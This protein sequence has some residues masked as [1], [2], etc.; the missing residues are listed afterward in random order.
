M[1]AH[2]GRKNQEAL[3]SLSRCRELP[4]PYSPELVPNACR[5]LTALQCPGRVG[6][7]LRQGITAGP[8]QPPHL[9][10]KE[11]G[12]PWLGNAAP[13]TGTAGRPPGCEPAG[14]CYPAPRHKASA[15]GHAVV[16]EKN[17]N[18]PGRATPPAPG[19]G[20]WRGTS[21]SVPLRRGHGDSH[22]VPWHTRQIPDQHRETNGPGKPCRKGT[23][24]LRR[25]WLIGTPP[26]HSL[27]PD[28]TSASLPDIPQGS[29]AVTVLPAASAQPARGRDGSPPAAPGTGSS[30]A[31]RCRRH[32][33]WDS[34]PSTY[35]G[36][37]E[38]ASPSG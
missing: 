27:T 17:Q 7:T 38:G 30:S 3:K 9:A 29:H 31:A 21:P 25:V 12:A 19:C 14:I 34:G 32:R 16:C 28:V 13:G 11:V 20:G 24:T 33:G 6:E 5:A 36:H 8:L 22:T 1:P 35:L 18:S 15:Q 10:S 2:T 37:R 26:G 4:T 23:Q